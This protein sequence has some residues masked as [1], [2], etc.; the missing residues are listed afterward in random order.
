MEQKLKDFGVLRAAAILANS[1]TL[2]YLP[3]NPVTPSTDTTLS[4]HGRHSGGEYNVFRFDITFAK[5]SLTNITFKTE[6]S[7][8][9]TDWYQTQDVTYS[10]GAM[11]SSAVSLVLTGSKTF[12]LIVKTKANFVRLSSTDTGTVTSS[13]LA[14]SGSCG[15]E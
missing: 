10:T 8:N 4:G 7:V 15:V 11:T 6:E 13:S 12:P 14:I 5:G 3:Y 9:G 1:E 2:V